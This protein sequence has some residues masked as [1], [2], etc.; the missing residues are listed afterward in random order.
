ME[1]PATSSSTSMAT[2]RSTSAS[3]VKGTWFS[4]S[5]EVPKK[6]MIPIRCSESHTWSNSATASK[7]PSRTT[8]S[9][10]RASRAERS[11][12]PSSTSISRPLPR[13]A[14]IASRASASFTSSKAAVTSS[15]SM[16]QSVQPKVSMTAKSSCIRSVIPS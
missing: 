2:A 12:I 1:W 8:R 16:G 9:R 11:I 10:A 7:P 5:R 14:S 6:G 4:S 15:W 13:S 3:Q